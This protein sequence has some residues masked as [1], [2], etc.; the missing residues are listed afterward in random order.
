MSYRNLKYY[1]FMDNIGSDKLFS[2]LMGHGLF[3]EK[4]PPLFTSVPFLNFFEQNKGNIIQRN[5]FS[6]KVCVIPM[7]PE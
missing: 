5:I 3:P 4:L 7:F 6:M 1:Q 2:G